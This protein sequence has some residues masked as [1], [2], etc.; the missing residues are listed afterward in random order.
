V[1][2]ITDWVEVGRFAAHLDI[3]MTPSEFQRADCAPRSTL[4]N[5]VLTVADWV[6]AGRYAVGLDPL[7]PAGGP[8][9]GPGSPS[10]KRKNENIN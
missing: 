2:S 10:P 7:T 4:G 9:Q 5:G 8:T 6:Q 1:V 3:P